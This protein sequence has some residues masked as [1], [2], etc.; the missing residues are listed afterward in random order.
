[1]VALPKLTSIDPHVDGGMSTAAC[2]RRHGDDAAASQGTRLSGLPGISRNGGRK[3]R[4]GDA[5]L[6]S[7]Q[8]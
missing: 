3:H 4:K 6:E 2:R 7:D 8:A 5:P 1:M